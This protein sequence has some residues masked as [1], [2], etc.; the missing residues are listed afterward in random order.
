MKKTILLGFV[1][2]AIVLG[3]ATAQSNTN[4]S[5]Y[6]TA[7]GAKF[8]PG[9]ITLKHFV[10]EKNAVEVLGYFWNRGS[11]I[12]GLYEIH[13]N[14]EGAPGLKWYIGPGAHV[15]FY[16]NKYYL[17]KSYFGLDGVL[18]L[19]YKIRTAPINLSLDWQP[20][21]EFGDGAGFSGNW[22]GLAVRYV[23]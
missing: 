17:G 19:D 7:L 15:A 11:R 6:T 20:S 12:T 4:S 2:V 3:S 10:T 9:A 13:G 16:N 18:G 8:Y 23:F 14:I 1:L 21:F 22:G 5:N